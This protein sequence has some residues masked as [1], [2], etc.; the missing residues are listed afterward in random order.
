MGEAEKRPVS[1]RVQ[2]EL[3]EE[4]FRDL[5]EITPEYQDLAYQQMYD[6]SKAEHTLIEVT[7]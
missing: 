7:H 4:Q 5:C 1:E 3:S 6:F 2:S